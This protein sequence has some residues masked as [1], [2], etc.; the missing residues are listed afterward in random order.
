MRL[1]FA[2]GAFDPDHRRAEHTNA[3]DIPVSDVSR[4]FPAAL[5]R[6]YLKAISPTSVRAVGEATDGRWAIIAGASGTRK[7]P[8]LERP[9]QALSKAN[10]R[11]SSPGETAEDP[12]GTE[13]SQP[14]LAFG[15]PF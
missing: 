14:V 4:Q 11:G 3:A 7:A 12:D 15:R 10:R 6:R 13:L 8:T 9:R 2:G 1:Q 5:S